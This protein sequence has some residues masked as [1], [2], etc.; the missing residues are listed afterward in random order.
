MFQPTV[1]LIASDARGSKRLPSQQI[2]RDVASDP[3]QPGSKTSAIIAL[4]PIANLLRDR[5]KHLLNQVI[6]IGR[7]QPLSPSHSKHQ[8]TIHQHE[9]IPRRHIRRIWQ[10]QNQTRSCFGWTGRHKA[11]TETFGLVF[12]GERQEV[13]YQSCS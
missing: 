10:P 13:S 12:L 3:Q 11:S 6:R 2:Y 8:R 7:L 4:K 5:R 9:L 1:C